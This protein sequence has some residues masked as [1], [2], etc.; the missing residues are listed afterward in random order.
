MEPNPKLQ[1]HP[2]SEVWGDMPARE[3]DDLVEDVRLHEVQHPI[4]VDDDRVL[5]GWHR[6]KAAEKAGVVLPP[7]DLFAGDDPVEFVI[8]RNAHRRHLTAEQR[9]VA[10]LAVYKVAKVGHNQHS[11]A[12]VDHDGPPTLTNAELAEKARVSPS[13]MKRTKKAVRDGHGDDIR[14][15]K[16]T[17]TS[18]RN[19][20]G[21]PPRKKVAKPPRKKAS[22]E[23]PVDTSAELE[24]ENTAL[25]KKV[26]QLERK[27]GTLT[28]R[29]TTCSEKLEEAKTKA[30]AEKRGRSADRKGVIGRLYER[31]NAMTLKTIAQIAGCSA[32]TVRE[33]PDPGE[34]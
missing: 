4:V 1:R 13:T 8:S 11:D 28:K 33:D 6:Y 24:E 18:L 22:A 5:D 31:D 14:E 9:A 2:L 21:K 12:G 10:I 27:V 3:F 19:Q 15:G 29:A 34:P 20:D 25:L 30:T 16:E 26:D 32:S 7:P 17:L 23:K